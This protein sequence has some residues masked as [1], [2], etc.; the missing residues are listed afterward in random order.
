[1]GNASVTCFAGEENMEHE[2]QI[3]SK[4]KVVELT[5]FAR[6]V[7]LNTIMGL[8]GSLHDVDTKAEIRIVVKPAGAARS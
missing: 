7:M 1:M 3:E 2:I 6:R 5:P 4:G 8:V